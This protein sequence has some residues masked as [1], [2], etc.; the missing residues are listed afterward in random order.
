MNL[1]NLAVPINV[2]GTLS[3]PSVGPDPLGAAANT[4]DFAARAANTATFGAL[5]SLTGL[6]ESNSLGDNPCLGAAAAGA[7]AKQSSSATD[8]IKEGL[9]TA[10]EGVGQGAKELG[11][12]AADAA[13]KA[14]EAT[15][16]ALDD[17]GKSL[18]GN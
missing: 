13:K 7:K 12:G 6:G 16:K 18:F 17:L 11:Q 5:S 1:A 15:G 2:G 4:A 14:G 10:A 8:K 9:G 3:H